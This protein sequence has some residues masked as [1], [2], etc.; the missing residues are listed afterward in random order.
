MSSFKVAVTCVNPVVQTKITPA[1]QAVVDT[2]AELTWFPSELL[3]AAG[4]EPKK[5]AVFITATGEKVERQIGYAIV[6]AD[7]K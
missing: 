5:K 6:C 3:Q 7:R 1:V 2:G 4:I